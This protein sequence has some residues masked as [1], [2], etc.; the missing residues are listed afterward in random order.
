MVAERAREPGSPAEFHP[1]VRAWL[2]EAFAA[3]T[4]AQE[5]GWPE[6]LAG[7]STLV[8][9]PTGSG[10]TLAAFLAAID[11]LM[12]SPL[13]ERAERCR[14]VYVSPLRA[15]AF[16]V[17]RN[18]RAPIAGIA[19]AASRRGDRFHLPTVA[20]RTGDTPAGE[21]ARMARTPPD[22]LITTPESLFLVLTSNARSILRSAELVIVDEIHTMVG[23]KRGAHLALSLE[24]LAEIA[25]VPPQRV[26]LSATQRPLDVVARY[27]VGY[28]AAPHGTAPT[29]LPPWES[30]VRSGEKS[31][32]GRGVGSVGTPAG[33]A[34]DRAAPRPYRIVDA[35][36]RKAFDLK[37][38]V[39]VEDMSRPGE[40][41]EPGDG[42]IP[43]GPASVLQRRSIW[44]AIYPRLLEL[45]RA[46]RS[47]LIFVNSRRLAER[48]AAQINEL[49]AAD[50]IDPIGGVVARAH[51]GSIAR[52]QRVEIEDA[53]KAGRLPA[54]VATSSLELGID[55]GAVDLVVQIETPPSVASG[56]QRIGRAGHQVEGV[57]RGVIFPKY[58]GDLLATAAITRAMADG[59]VEATRVPANPLDVLAQ[60][61]VAICALEE[62][63]VD[64]LYALVRRSAPFARL[65]RAQLEGVLDM[66]SGRYPP[67]DFAELRPRLVWDRLRG[68]VRAREGARQ[69]VVA[70]AGTIPDRGLYGVF[71]ADGSEPGAGGEGRGTGGPEFP[72]PGRPGGRRVGELDEEMVFETRV[73][74]IVVLGASSWR[75][76]EISRDRV[77]VVPAPGEPGKMPFWRGDRAVRPV[78]LGET[79][80]RLTRELDAAPREKA[81]ARLVSDHGLEP[82]AANNLLAYLQE[83][84]AATGALP[85]DRTLVVERSRDEMGDWRLC[86]LS[87]WGGR[88]HAPWALVLQARL[89]AAG[90]GAASDP[91]A[92]VPGADPETVW[93]DD[94]IVVRLPDRDAP[95]D[96]SLL[97]PEPDE[98]EELVIRELGGSALFAAHFREAA[99]RAL[100]LPRHRPGQRAPLWMQRRRAADLLQ[101]AS[102]YGS[103]P[104]ILETYRECLQDVFD[105]PAFVELARKIRRREL[106]VVTVDTEAP[107]PFAATLLFGYVANYIYDGDAPLAE[108]RAQALSVDQA[109]LRELLG[110]PELRELLD[111]Q[112]LEALEL[113]LQGLDDDHHARSPDRVHD[114][115]LRL[116]DLTI[117][118]L[119]AR[120]ARPTRGGEELPATTHE[121]AE[122]WAGELVQARRAIRVTVAAEE[123][124]AA[125]EDAGRLRDALGVPPPP[126]LPG[127]FLE[128]VPE[129]LEQLVAR[130]ARTHGPFAAVDVARRYGMGEAPILAALR[131]LAT[132]GRVLEGEF[133][134]GASGREWCDPNVLATLR[135]RSLARLRKQVEPAGLAA[136]ARLLLDWHGIRAPG[137][138]R[139]AR[140]G[141]PDRLLDVTE[142]IQ[143]A[144][145]P[146]STLERDVLP[147]RLPGYRPRDLD[148]LCAAGEV[149]WAGA[150]PLGERDGRIALYLADDLPLLH[151]RQPEPPAGDVHDRLREH[152]GRHGASFFADL[153]A[154]AG[155]PPGLVVDALWDLV[156]AGELTVDTPGALRA[157]LGSGGRGNGGQAPRADRPIGQRRRIGPFR[158]RRQAPPSAVGRWSLLQADGATGPVPSPTER[159]R[160]VAQQM[161]ARHGVLTRQAVL[162]EGL[163]GGFATVYPVLAAMEEAGRVRRGYFVTGL[164][165]SQFADPGAL[166]RLRALRES[167]PPDADDALPA[168]VLAATDPANP[169]GAALAWP[170]ME[171]TR[172]ARAAGA[173]V[174]LV[175]GALAAYLSRGERELT[176]FLPDDEPARSEAAR[177]LA[178]ALARWAAATGRVLPG[179]T[180]IDDAPPPQSP[181]ARYLQEAGFAPA[182]RGFRLTGGVMSDELRVMSRAGNPTHHSSLIT[183]HS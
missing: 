9:A 110:E 142:Q 148:L 38:V 147:A 96:A 105:L 116:G 58:R 27:L 129:A 4:R 121:L 174:V 13:P 46:H 84:K 157:F 47:T 16:D 140:D 126:G 98:I 28:E 164:G 183:H 115:L 90:I 57:S 160:A 104:I 78:E 45:V 172:L 133:R 68:A 42:E 62:R 124:V 67:D 22:V 151:A 167:I 99:G 93:S 141:G 87:P 71:L 19:R 122:R 103:F 88:V 137:S 145:V 136:L 11:R 72:A 6:I 5:L 64:D 125:A 111:P 60:Q 112:A 12:F 25:K 59:A 91:D 54:M 118:E 176:T 92:L 26:G 7:H 76:V 80:G 171:G 178:R 61:L 135:R 165:G 35:G 30:P 97:L 34:T 94:G 170:R 120:V 138:S 162:A 56:I 173:Y 65:A 128:P 73:G 44:P 107:S 63:T 40:V 117:D 31:Q 144:V 69:L 101:V 70:N 17:E 23:T 51:H 50:G 123:R 132:A 82:G 180:A 113:S 102:R 156:W 153:Q 95:P 152:L 18:L 20:L 100:L 179:W 79:I 139:A 149:V 66:L 182:G 89:R 3:P 81:A 43:E 109:Q 24:R 130:Y 108:R 49:A 131:T 74:E 146:A 14:V 53:L 10:K 8:F 143:G 158:S 85:D 134:P 86:L 15:L 48:V 159:L 154:A 37:V 177:D 52:E 163:A 41:I 155:G 32:G 36:A 127:A 181:L 2:A 106:R 21:R 77:Q 169:Y 29:P 75:V 161:V 119:A 83:Q 168:V 150:G 175:D 55:M 166:D 1:A 114:L 39:P 33:S